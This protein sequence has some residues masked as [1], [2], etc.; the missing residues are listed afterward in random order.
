MVLERAKKEGLEKGHL[1]G[2]EEWLEEA[3]LKGKAEVVSN[4]IS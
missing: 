3:I 4:L 2:R 1:K